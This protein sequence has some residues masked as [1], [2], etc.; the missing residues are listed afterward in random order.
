MF[1]TGKFAYQIKPTYSPLIYLN[2]KP[3]LF[4]YIVPQLSPFALVLV[5]TRRNA[6]Q[7]LD[8]VGYVVHHGEKFLLH[9]ALAA[10]GL[11]CFYVLYYREVS[12]VSLFDGGFP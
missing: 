12:V 5:K 1:L 2:I 8:I 9:K 7:P 10:L 4:S 6:S 11:P 3:K